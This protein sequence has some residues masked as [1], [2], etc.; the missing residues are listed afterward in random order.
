MNFYFCFAGK[1]KLFQKSFLKRSEFFFEK[2]RK[3]SEP[4]ILLKKVRNFI[5]KGQK[6]FLKKSESFMREIRKLFEKSQ[7]NEP[8]QKYFL[9]SHK[10]FRKS[11]KTFRKKSE[12][13]FK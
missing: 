4:W 1:L 13:Y 11:H 8:G 10:T 3:I 7:K 2:A 9:K 5:G 12:I 6:T